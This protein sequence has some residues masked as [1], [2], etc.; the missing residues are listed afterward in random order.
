MF[1]RRFIQQFLVR[2]VC[3]AALMICAR[4]VPAQSS[5]AVVS[6]A[7]FSANAIA[8]ESIASAY[9]ANLATRFAVAETVPL[10]TSLGGTTVKINDKPAQ[11]F[12]VSPAQINFLIPAGTAE[13]PAW[14]T[15]T[16]AALG[17]SGSRSN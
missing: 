6:S 2:C 7:N 14:V 1:K 5:V 15:I 9:G 17:G 8:P 10:P 13:G 4:N 16:G 3:L 11:L 12:F